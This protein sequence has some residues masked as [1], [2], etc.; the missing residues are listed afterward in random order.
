MSCVWKKTYR[1]LILTILA[2]LFTRKQI[3]LFLQPSQGSWGTPTWLWEKQQRWSVKC[4]ALHPSQYLGTMMVQKYKAGPTMR[5]PSATTAALSAFPHWSFQTLECT[6][7]KQS[8]RQDHVK[9]QPPWWS[10]VSPCHP[11]VP[12]HPLQLSY[13]CELST[14]DCSDGVCHLNT[15]LYPLPEPPSFVVPPQPVEAMPGSKV[16]FSAIVKGSSPLKLKCFRGTKELLSGKDCE[17]SLKDNQVVLELLNVDRS[18]AGEYTCQII[19]DAGKESCAVNLSVKGQF[20]G[21]HLWLCLLHSLHSVF[22]V[23]SL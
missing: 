2:S 7:V 1:Q 5:F 12:V 14:S 15:V 6:N 3:R 18:H 21:K 20:L 9:Q 8:T 16:T 11:S 23:L 19:N 22:K 10:K 4:Q 13:L 17:F